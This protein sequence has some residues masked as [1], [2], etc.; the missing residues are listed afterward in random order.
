M[1]EPDPRHRYI[2]L[3]VAAAVVVAIP[4]GLAAEQCGRALQRL[5]VLHRDGQVADFVLRRVAELVARLRG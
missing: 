4:G 5:Q 1:S 3:V 2:G